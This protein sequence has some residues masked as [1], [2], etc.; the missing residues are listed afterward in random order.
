MTDK[1]RIYMVLHFTYLLSFPLSLSFSLSVS[2]WFF[3]FRLSTCIISFFYLS[4]YLW[5]KSFKLFPILLYIAS[6]YWYDLDITSLLVDM[7]IFGKKK[8]VFFFYNSLHAEDLERK[9]KGR[10]EKQE[11]NLAVSVHICKKRI[12]PLQFST[13]ISFSVFL[14][15]E[16]AT[17]IL[18]TVSWLIPCSGTSE[19]CS[20]AFFIFL[21]YYFFFYLFSSWATTKKYPQIIAVFQGNE[22]SSLPRIHDMC[23]KRKELR[24]FS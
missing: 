18:V 16:M 15:S 8:N 11:N 13:N 22:P 23:R 5:L 12:L 24:S 2:L 1:Y 7:L 4:F 6:Q 19:G 9:N 20:G 21:Y 14:E 3:F 17:K 10:K